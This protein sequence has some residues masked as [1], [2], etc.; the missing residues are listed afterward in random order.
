LSGQ[1]REAA[2]WL[3]KHLALYEQRIQELKTK[4]QREAKSDEDMQRLQTVAGVGPVVAY[5]YVAH[6]GNGERFSRSSQVSNYLGLVPRLEYSG[7][8]RRQGH[9]TKRGNGYVRSLLY[10]SAWI[11]VRTKKG[12]ALRERFIV[13][14]K[15]KGKKQSIRAI[16]R[17]LRELLYSLLRNKTVYEERPWQGGNSGR[18]MAE[19]ALSA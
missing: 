16:A 2:E 14:T 4:I 6:V 11:L 5:A 3:L 15:T 7:T 1:E 17:R 19:E 9:I 12:G 18:R 13:M 10:Q 8:I